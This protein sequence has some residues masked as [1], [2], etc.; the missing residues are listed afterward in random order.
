MELFLCMYV[1]FSTCNNQTFPWSNCSIKIFAKCKNFIY[2]LIKIWCQRNKFLGPASLQHSNSMIILTFLQFW[3]LGDKPS[4]QPLDLKASAPSPTSL[5][6]HW[7]D[8]LRSHWNGAILG[9]RAGWRR[10]RYVMC[11]LL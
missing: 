11:E 8:P 4:G 6:L 3:T 5:L 1:V 7:S 10:M 9:Y 2:V